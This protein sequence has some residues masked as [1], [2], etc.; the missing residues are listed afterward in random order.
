VTGQFKKQ[1]SL[2]ACGDKRHFVQFECTAALIFPCTLKVKDVRS[3]DKF[4]V[5]N[6][7]QP[8]TIK[9]MYGNLKVV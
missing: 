8:P 1:S 4:N 7:V 6:S 9:Y 3:Y 2:L 5:L